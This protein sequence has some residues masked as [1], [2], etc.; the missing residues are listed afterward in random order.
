MI[1]D[2]RLKALNLA[3]EP[4]TPAETVVERARIYAQFILGGGPLEREEIDGPPASI[5][6]G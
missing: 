2:L 1:E 3:H 5:P 6:A 4:D